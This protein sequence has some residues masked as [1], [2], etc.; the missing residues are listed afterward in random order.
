MNRREF[1]I[2]I[3]TVV[4]C[5]SLISRQVTGNSFPGWKESIQLELSTVLSS[6]A[7][8]KSPEYRTA[9]PHSMQREIVAEPWVQTM[10]PATLLGGIT[11]ALDRA[12]LLN[13]VANTV[14]QVFDTDPSV[15][16]V[17]RRGI[18][19]IRNADVLVDAVDET[20]TLLG[21]DYRDLEDPVRHMYFALFQRLQ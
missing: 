14:V 4:C 2:R 11:E 8:V 5:L 13:D 18:A 21:V 6:N 19:P 3:A 10:S 12:G 15:Y 9:I 17:V 1:Q 7:L 20:S 16:S